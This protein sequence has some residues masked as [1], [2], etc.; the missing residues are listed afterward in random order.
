[1]GGGV[2]MLKPLNQ[3]P[4]AEEFLVKH[5]SIVPGPGSGNPSYPFLYD[6][7]RYD[8]VRATNLGFAGQNEPVPHLANFKNHWVV[9][10]PI[11][12][13]QSDDP[14]YDPSYGY[15]PFASELTHKQASIDFFYIVTGAAWYLRQPVNADIELSYIRQD[16]P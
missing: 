11:G 1:M 5:W 14:V 8:V 4:P 15:G 6:P 16:L 3:G 10:Y 9:E 12:E 7:P 13:P 2:M